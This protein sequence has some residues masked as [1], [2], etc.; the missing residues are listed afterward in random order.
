MSGTLNKAIDIPFSS[1]AGGLKT[2]MPDYSDIRR[3]R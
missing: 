3:P 2:Y 1:K